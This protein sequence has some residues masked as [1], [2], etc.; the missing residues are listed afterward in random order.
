MESRS[1]SVLDAPLSRSMTVFA[2]AM[3]RSIQTPSFRGDANGS[4][5][6]AALEPICALGPPDLEL[7]QRA[8]HLSE[9]PGGTKN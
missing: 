8:S 9:E 3:R 4:A 6:R 5:Q 7:P 1:R 2:S